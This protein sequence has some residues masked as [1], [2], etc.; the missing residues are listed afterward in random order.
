[1][2][3]FNVYLRSGTVLVIQCD[4]ADAGSEVFTF[5]NGA[6]PE[7]VVVAQF[8]RAAICGFAQQDSIVTP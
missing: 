3:K 4:E 2:L 7:V 6:A 1:M 8:E 5:T